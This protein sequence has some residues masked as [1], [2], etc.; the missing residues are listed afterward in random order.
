MKLWRVDDVMTKDVV[1]VP[2]DL[3]YH[4]VV[5]VLIDNRISA[6]PVMDRFERAVGIVSESDL[7][8]KMADGSGAAPA[9]TPRRRRALRKAHGRLARD[10]MSSPVVTAMPS[11]SLAAAARRMQQE[12]VKRLVVEDT[13]GRIRGIV[14]RSDLLKVHVRTD[15]AIRHD[16][17]EEVMR[18]VLTGERGT[19]RVTVTDGVVKLTG[20]VR[21][22]SSAKAAARLAAAVPGVVDVADLVDYDIDD[23]L[24]VGTP[25]GVA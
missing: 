13:L 23:G 18:R 16:I 4:A 25:F 20:R 19:V 1:S 5:A 14:T 11:L 7:L 8:M 9:V 10:V 24:A 21:L 3:P 2:E 17:A 12:N 15:E 22:H 6:V